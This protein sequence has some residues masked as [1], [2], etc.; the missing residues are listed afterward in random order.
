M[1]LIRKVVVI[2]AKGYQVVHVSR[3]RHYLAISAKGGG[4]VEICERKEFP[5]DEKPQ[6]PF[7]KLGVY[8]QPDSVTPHYEW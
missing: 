7:K 3:A 1:D 5:P 6:P 2:T 4:M 8:G